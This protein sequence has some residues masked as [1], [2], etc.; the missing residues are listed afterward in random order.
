MYKEVFE[1][2][3]IIGLPLLNIHTYQSRFIPEEVAEAFHT[4]LRD[5]HVLPK[6][7]SFEKLR[8]KQSVRA[9]CF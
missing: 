9:L 4:F 1:Y 7:L 6:L 8:C 3:C 2:V 5:A